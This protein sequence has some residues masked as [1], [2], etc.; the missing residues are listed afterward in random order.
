MGGPGGGG[1]PP[2]GGGG[3]VLHKR[4]GREGK[5]EAG[6][7]EGVDVLVM[8]G[9]GSLAGAAGGT[10]DTADTGLGFS[11]DSDPDVPGAG[12]EEEEEGSDEGATC[13]FSL[14]AEPLLGVAALASTR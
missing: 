3:G 14:D 7:E 4:R 8:T 2:G 6:V 1:R 5:R 13:T 12:D 9:V 10:V 11:M